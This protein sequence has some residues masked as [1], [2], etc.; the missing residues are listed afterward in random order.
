MVKVHE[1]AGHDQI[2]DNADSKSAQTPL[3]NLLDE[4]LRHLMNLLQQPTLTT[5][6]KVKLQKILN[7]IDNDGDSLESAKTGFDQGAHDIFL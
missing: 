7:S 2:S 3:E 5:V 6:N 1:N 4:I